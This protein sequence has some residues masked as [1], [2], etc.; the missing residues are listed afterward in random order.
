MLDP[1]TGHLHYLNPSAAYIYALICEYGFEGAL[2]KIASRFEENTPMR[3]EL[4]AL[5]EDMRSKGLL[6]GD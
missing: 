4:P 3:R 6:V 5:L 2:Q 1:E